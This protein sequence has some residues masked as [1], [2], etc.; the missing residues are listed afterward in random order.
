MATNTVD[1]L[2]VGGGVMEGATLGTLLSKLNP[3]LRLTMVERLDH[4]AH[5]STD[6][7]NNA[8]TGHAGYCELNYTPR[9]LLAKLRST[10]PWPSMPISKYRC[11]LWTALT[12]SGDLPAPQNFIN[13]TP[14]ISFVW[15]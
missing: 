6:G 15:G 1:V 9:M 10:A 8:G 3:S 5:E 4:V 14:H 11:R 13:P 2:L 12:A 7:W